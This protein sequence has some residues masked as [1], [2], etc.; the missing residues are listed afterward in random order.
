MSEPNGLPG[1]RDNSEPNPFA[2]PVLPP[3]V[4]PTATLTAGFWLLFAGG[5]VLFIALSYFVPGLGIPATVS[6]LAAAIRTPMLLQA[7]KR[8]QG[9]LASLPNIAESAVRLPPAP[10]VLI[11]SWLIT[12]AIGIASTVI[13]CLICFPSSLLV[14]A[15]TGISGGDGVWIALAWGTSGVLALI[16]YVLLF[17]VSL[18]LPF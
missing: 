6:L 17:R 10:I 3:D 4:R 15:L 16:S 13:F 8:K 18:R 7:L 1:G 11:V 12:L 9:A 14:L 5:L 2:P